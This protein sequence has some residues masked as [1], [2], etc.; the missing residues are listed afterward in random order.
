MDFDRLS[1][2]LRGGYTQK[3]KRLDAR[4]AFFVWKSLQAI[5]GEID[6]LIMRLDAA[7]KL[8][9]ARIWT[10]LQWRCRRY[11]LENTAGAVQQARLCRRYARWTISSW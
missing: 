11:Q 5:V 10:R 4:P 3:P 6:K 8:S 7:K 2:K 9:P 1:E